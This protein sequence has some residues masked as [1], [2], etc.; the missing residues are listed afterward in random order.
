MKTISIVSLLFFLCIPLCTFA[1]NTGTLSELASKSKSAIVTIKIFGPNLN[2]IGSGSGFFVGRNGELITSYHVLE[3]A[4]KASVITSM[5]REFSI[6]AVLA[7]NQDLDIV[8]VRVSIPK[9]IIYTLSLAKKYP[10][11]AEDVFVIGSPLGLS[12]SITNGIISHVP[13]EPACSQKLSPSN[14]IQFSAP[15]SPGSSGSPVIDYKGEV[16]GIVTFMISGGQ[17]LNFAVPSACLHLMRVLPTP[18]PLEKWSSKGCKEK[19][20]K[21]MSYVKKGHCKSAIVAFKDIIRITPNCSDAYYGLGLAYNAIALHSGEQ[22]KNTILL[23]SLVAL[24]KAVAINPSYVEAHCELGYVYDCFQEYSRAV[25]HLKTAIKIDPNYLEAY[26]NLGT[27]YAHMGRYDLAINQVKILKAHSASS[28][29]FPLEYLIEW[30]ENM[31]SRKISTEENINSY[32]APHSNEKNARKSNE[33]IK[34]Y[35]DKNGT[36]VISE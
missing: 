19:S 28:M 2:K 7:E 23:N 32:R 33:G 17:N 16:V 27:V 26:V 1:S 11:T 18:L 25:N 15:I 21:A 5:N 35:E 12:Q 30:F 8:K 20:L 9:N 4:H 13:E 22:D 29:A 24:K 14:T 36:I 31:R 6:V 34:I 3:N 10:V